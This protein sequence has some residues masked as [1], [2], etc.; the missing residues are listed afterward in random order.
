MI[1]I[2]QITDRK[3]RGPKKKRKTLLTGYPQKKGYCMRVYETKPKK[4][5]SA[6]RKVAK[7]T[8]KLKNKRKN[9]IAYIPGFGPHNLQPLSTVL[10][11]GGRCQDLQIGRAHV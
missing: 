1:T 9:L 8:I 4:P 6:I 3:A 5:N 2:N 11:K 7:V 10:V